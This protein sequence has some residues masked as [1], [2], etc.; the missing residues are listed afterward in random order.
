M[1]APILEYPDTTGGVL[2]LD[3]DASNGAIGAVLSQIQYGKEI[4]IKY[5]SGTLNSAE[6][7]HC[8][9]RKEILALVLFTRTVNHSKN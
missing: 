2:M 3:T 4:V 9:T 8:V 1:T 6:K 7:N 5:A